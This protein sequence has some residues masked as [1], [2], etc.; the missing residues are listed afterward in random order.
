MFCDFCSAQD[1][2]RGRRVQGTFHEKRL[3]AKGIPQGHFAQCN[4]ADIFSSLESLF[5]QDP[6]RWNYL[7]GDLAAKD[8]A[9]TQNYE[10]MKQYLD[11]TNFADYIIA[12]F[13]VG[14]TDWPG[15]NWYVIMRGGADPLPAQF[16]AW[17]GEWSLDRQQV[18]VHLW[19][20]R[21][22][23]APGILILSC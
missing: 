16:Q 12:S 4:L 10:E 15:N 20:M 11:V 1:E 23:A 17:D 2:S 7:I 8:M 6:T 13:Y 22:F 5:V 18:N 21:G 9:A 3:S 14:E 19:S